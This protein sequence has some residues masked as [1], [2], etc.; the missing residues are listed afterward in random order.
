MNYK[1]TDTEF[2]LEDPQN[3]GGLYMPLVNEKVMSCITPDGHGG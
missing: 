3:V 1:I 2:R